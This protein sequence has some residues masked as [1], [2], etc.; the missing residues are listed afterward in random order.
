M[1]FPCFRHCTRDWRY[2]VESFKVCG[3]NWKLHLSGENTA[4]LS[5][6]FSWAR[7]HQIVSVNG[8]ICYPFVSL[9]GSFHTL[10]ICYRMLL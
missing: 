3:E 7:T 10:K 2:K 5:P 6:G 9:Q 4:P 8:K 1:Y